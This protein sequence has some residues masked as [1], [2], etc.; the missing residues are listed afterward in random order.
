MWFEVFVHKSQTIGELGGMTSVL[1]SLL[2]VFW[3]E[4]GHDMATAGVELQLADGSA[5]HIWARFETLLADEG[6]L[7]ATLGCKGA[8]GYRPCLL[9]RNVYNAGTV[10]DAAIADVPHTCPHMEQFQL[11]TPESLQAIAKTLSAVA[12]AGVQSRLKEAQTNL[13]WNFIKRSILWN[14]R[15]FSLACPSWAACFDWMHVYFIDGVW[16]KHVG[17]S[18]HMVLRHR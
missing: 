18:R 13:G 5:Q 6:A 10:R 4:S 12:A 11:H 8:S 17:H 7:H 1:G 2:D 14:D 3:N 16:N 15:W 9:C